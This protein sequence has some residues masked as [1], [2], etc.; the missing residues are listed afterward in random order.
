MVEIKKVITSKDVRK[1]VDFPE[2]LYKGNPYYVPNL[3]IDE[4]NKFDKRKNESFEDCEIQA[5][6]AYKNNK[7]VGRICAIIQKL[8]N[9]KHNEKRVRFS[10]FDSINDI[11]VAKAL[12]DAV[13]DWAKEKGMNIAHGPMGYNDLDREGLLI[14]GFDQYQTFEEQY[15]HPYYPKLIE[16]CGYKKEVDW[17]ECRLFTPKQV[18]PKVERLSQAVLSRYNLKIAECKNIKELVSRYV[19]GVFETLDEAYSNL[20]GT[21]PFTDKVK[22][23]VVSQFYL[24]LRKEFIVI[25]TDKNDKVV[26]FG[27]CFPSLSNAVNKSKGR[28]FP[29]GIFRLLKA[30]KQVDIIDLGLIAVKPEYQNKGLNAVVLNY[31]ISQMI[32]LGVSAA[33]TNLMLE[34]NFKIQQ[35][36]KF[37]DYIQHKRRRAY[38]KLL[39]P[40]A[41]L[42]NQPIEDIKTIVEEKHTVDAKTVS[43]KKKTK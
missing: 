38:Y 6:L 7:L 15:N 9:Q 23:A 1:F 8:Y 13:E 37:F 30:K 33:E 16:E 26:A 25:V 40:D 32:K 11:E 17:L 12:F 5:F 31:M 21:V 4:I 22:K 39:T 35:Q 41:K 36:W 27:L 10:R 3:R 14:E 2:K 20:Y 18:D 42:K 34:D 24:I 29:T 43:A 28:L 19:D